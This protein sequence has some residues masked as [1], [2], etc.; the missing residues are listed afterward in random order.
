VF[1]SVR[2]LTIFQEEV[3]SQSVY[4]VNDTTN[5]QRDMLANYDKKQRP[6]SQTNLLLEFGLL[7]ITKLVGFSFVDFLAFFSSIHYYYFRNV[8][9]R[10]L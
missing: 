1:I 2:C 6:Q 4:T 9:P 8:I 3:A 7:H 10:V 5:L